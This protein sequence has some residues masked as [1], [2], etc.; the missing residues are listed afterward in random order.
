MAN[1]RD[2][3]I[4]D[5]DDVVNVHLFEINRS[6]NSAIG[7]QRLKYLYEQVLNSSS[8]VLLVAIE[9]GQLVGFICGTSSYHDFVHDLEKDPLRPPLG[10]LMDFT[11]PEHL[12]A[13]LAEMDAFIDA[14]IKPLERE[15][16]QY[17]DRR[18]EFARTDLDAL[19]INQSLVWK[20]RG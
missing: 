3:T 6:I 11:L 12:P 8:G 7:S 17:F 20:D 16:M 9:D 14:E 18:R 2:A 15:N 19:A 5:V 13:L 1:V 10:E 4:F